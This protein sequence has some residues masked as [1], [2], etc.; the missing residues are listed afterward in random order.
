MP[1]TNATGSQYITMTIPRLFPPLSS[2]IAIVIAGIFGGLLTTSIALTIYARVLRKN[3]EKTVIQVTRK[4][5]QQPSRP[6]VVQPSKTISEPKTGLSLEEVMTNMESEREIVKML[7]VN[8]AKKKLGI[9]EAKPTIVQDIGIEGGWRAILI[10]QTQSGTQ[11]S[12]TL[13]I[14]PKTRSVQR[15]TL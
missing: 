6:F 1:Q 9:S 10:Q 7:A 2:S 13:H 12:I 5:E 14:D 3:Y 15:A 11:K 8:Y 4:T